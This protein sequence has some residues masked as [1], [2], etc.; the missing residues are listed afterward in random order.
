MPEEAELKSVDEPL[1][2][3]SK[4]K[5]PVEAI[6]IG[7]RRKRSTTLARADEAKDGQTEHGQT[8]TDHSIDWE[9]IGRAVQDKGESTVEVSLVAMNGLVAAL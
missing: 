5:V 3:A 9:S 2:N 1:M 8:K 7:K 6:G 4:R